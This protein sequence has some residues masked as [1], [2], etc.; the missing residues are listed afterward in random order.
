MGFVPHLLCSPS[1]NP[2]P[3]PFQTPASRFLLNLK[4]NVCS[5]TPKCLLNTGIKHNCQLGV[6]ARPPNGLVWAAVWTRVSVSQSESVWVYCRERHA[7]EDRFVCVHACQS[8]AQL[9]ALDH[10]EQRTFH[11]TPLRED[12]T[13][14]SFFKVPVHFDVRY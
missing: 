9:T 7:C 12:R 1:S 14:D 8:P 6:E 2:Q 10:P 11:L 5:T 3:P 4:A 13:L